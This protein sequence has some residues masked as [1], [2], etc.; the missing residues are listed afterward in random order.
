MKCW[1]ASLTLLDE[2]CQVASA[3][4]GVGLT[5][6]F[7]KTVAS[8]ISILLNS[9]VAVIIISYRELNCK[10]NNIFLLFIILSDLLGFIPPLL[11]IAYFFYPSDESF[12]WSYAAI[13]YLPTVLVLLNTFISLIDRYVA[14]HFQLWH[15]SK[16]T[17]PRVTFWLIV[18]FG[19]AVVFNMHVYIFQLAKREC[20]VHSL[21]DEWINLVMIFLLSLC[22]IAR[23]VVF[24][25]TKNVLQNPEEQ[26]STFDDAGSLRDSAV[27]LA[28]SSV[29]EIVI[30]LNNLEETANPT[31]MRNDHL[32]VPLSHSSSASAVDRVINEINDLDEDAIPPTMK[33]C[34]IEVE[35]RETRLNQETKNIKLES[36]NRRSMMAEVASL[37]IFTC[38]FLLLNVILLII[39]P[40]V[41]ARDLFDRLSSLAPYFEQ[42]N[43]LLS[44]YNPFMHL[45]W[46]KELSLVLKKWH[47]PH[48][49][50]FK[51]IFNSYL[52]VNVELGTHICLLPVFF[53]DFQNTWRSTISRALRKRTEAGQSPFSVA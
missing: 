26:V 24:F 13:R 1:N 38:P 28:P 5:F 29:S 19:T 31:I 23:I 18:C 51:F 34:N 10:T 42:W 43:Q 16:V 6:L 25:Q 50:P 14:N 45:M 30:E 47:I 44:I 15:L 48:V 4:T 11:E 41:Q 20:Q 32:N 27:P 36:R 37:L 52:P 49:S 12:C 7:F 33:S 46:N 53:I 40:K 22:I 21:A 39:C 17:V 35:V 3:I 2:D 8:V 9:L